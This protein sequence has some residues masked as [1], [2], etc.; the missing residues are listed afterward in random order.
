MTE[1][2]S[3]LGTLFSSGI[4]A[5]AV[6]RSKR[7][8][9]ENKELKKSYNAL[10]ILF[11][12]NIFNNIIYHVNEAFK[13]TKADR[14]LTLYATNGKSDFRFVTAM[15]EHHKEGKHTRLSIGAV[16]KYVKV[17]T[18]TEYKKLL[19][20]A[21]VNGDKY[22]DVIEMPDSDLKNIYIAEKVFHSVVLFLNRIRMNDQNDLLLYCSIATH[23][24]E[25]FTAEEKTSLK[26]LAGALRNETEKLKN[27]LN[28]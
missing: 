20:D 14:Y 18:D 11:D 17:E 23:D 19:K 26:Q 2:L 6:V 27:N 4:A 13:K 10:D 28:N 3:F 8:E 12:F 16:N 15:F 1:L 5:W 24:P 22:L 25:P 9:K 7:I 21:E